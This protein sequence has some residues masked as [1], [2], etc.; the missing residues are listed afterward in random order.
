MV[1]LCLLCFSVLY[2]ATVPHPSQSHPTQSQSQSSPAALAMIASAAKKQQAV[3]RRR[4]AGYQT[5][6][7]KR[8]YLIHSDELS[9]DRW[10]NNGAQVL[11]GHVEFEHDG[12]RLL[13]DSANYFED[14]NS[15]EAFG[16]VRMYQGDTLSLTSDFGFYD[17]NDQMMQ[18]LQNV[19]LKNRQT[20][21][22]T[23]SL[24]YDR[25]WS[26]GYFQ[27]GGK[28]VDGTTTLTSDWGE[29]HADT[30]MA[31]FYYDVQMK[32]KRFFL[33]TDSL[34]YDTHGKLAHIVG[35]SD[36]TS[37]KSHIYS[38]LGYYSTDTEQGRL[39]NRSVLDNQGRILTGDSLWYDG[40]T[41]ISEAF[42]DI[43]YTDTVNK[44]KLTG[45][46]GYYEDSTGYAMCTDSAMTI[47]YSQRDSLY[48][49][50]D[51]FKVFTYNIRTDSVYRVIHA[52]NKVR[53]YRLDVQAVCDSL[54]YNSQDSCMTMYRDPIVW[55]QNQ[56][57]V[58]EQ[59]Q[60]FMKDS[61][62][63]HAHV[64]NQAFSVEQLPQEQMFNQV[65]STEMFAFFEKGQMHE[66]RAKDNVLVVYYPED[67]SDSSYV[68]LVYME[69]SE[70]RMFMENR[71]L[72][73]IWAPKSEG[74]MYPMSQIPPQ[75]R[76]LEGFNWFDYIRP[77]SKE[78]IFVW[79]PK[80]QG[81]ELKP[82]K[83]REAPKMKLPGLS[84]EVQKV[85]EVPGA[86]EAPLVPETPE[87]PETP[88]TQSDEEAASL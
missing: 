75:K 63:D 25:L 11:R 60:V 52:Y 36:I 81:T 23:D 56:Q 87:V 26:M 68:G 84:S 41:G 73:R 15:F 45:N 70:L 74:K 24:Y 53:A 82:Q 58:G 18:A 8:V 13:C 38:E 19:V 85:T 22:Y 64:I 55:N 51:T 72:Q 37:G 62:V 1:L 28:L 61:V 83:R 10:R 77:L 34:Y 48:M 35:P 2:A 29:Y 17:G 6:D 14:T 12:A 47:D 49:H 86:S 42:Y 7:K 31:V 33:T 40:K 67:E 32:D 27:E 80:K 4:P 78:D 88:A 21:L 16:H 79:R 9:Y 20:T 71:K 39:L 66:G 30:K 54:V 3:R 44:N 50:A 5:P 59:I 65:S 69:T 46:Y 76:F 57:L 43:V